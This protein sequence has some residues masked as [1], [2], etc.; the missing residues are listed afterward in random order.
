MAGAGTKT[1][2]RVERLVEVA[3]A[4]LVVHVL[5]LAVFRRYGLE[6]IGL[7]LSFRSPGPALALIL[8]LLFVRIRRNGR[9]TKG[10]DRLRPGN[11]LAG[12]G[13]PG[14][15]LTTCLVLVFWLSHHY[16]GRLGSDGVMN[17]IYVRSLVIDGDFDL[18][19]EFEDFVPEKHQFIAENARALGLTPDPTNEPGPAI[20]WAPAFVITHGLV[21]AS[22]WFGSQIPAD[23]Y[24]YPYINAVSVTSLLWGFVAV[25]VSY[26]V[27]RRYFDPRLAAISVCLLWLASTLYW[28]TVFEPTMPHATAA[29]AVSLFLYL[30]I[31][32]R[33]HPTTGGWIA[34][35][36]AGGM[37][38]A[39]QRYNVF[40]FAAPAVTAIGAVARPGLFQRVSRRSLIAA[41]IAIAGFL[42]AA[43][44]MFLYNLSHSQGLVRIG[45]LGGF[46]LRYWSSPRIGEFLFSSKH[47]LFSWTPA[48]FAAVAGLFLL[49]RKDLR[50]AATLLFTL[51]LGI[52]LLSSTWDWYAG[53]AFGSR[54][55]TEA[56]LIF[57]L[58]FCAVCEFLLRRP[59]LLATTGALAL[60]SWNMLLSGQL[61]RGEIPEMATFAFSDAAS[62]AARRTYRTLGHPGSVPANW[63]FA[64][65][66]GVSPDRFDTIYGHREFHNLTIDV[67]ASGDTHFVGRGWSEPESTS[68]GSTFRWSSGPESSFLLYLFEPYD[69]RLALMGEPSRHPKGSSQVILVNVNGQKAARLSLTE[70]WQTVEA[71]VPASFWKAGLNE[72]L[73][74][75]LWTVEAGEAYG[76][77]DGRQIA[78]KLERL[79]LQIIK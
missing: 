46:T 6:L 5:L 34:L 71:V 10:F 14:F 32:V 58:G 47:G 23:G 75:Y 13:L 2:A 67:G 73:L 8:L 61:K 41:A 42:L 4:L 63:I 60:V 20:L 54:R 11:W 22:R 65:R 51:G 19:N 44:P 16:G 12:M 49:L 29:A 68:D 30:W 62:R 3:L 18:T 1:P 9:A 79:D 28:Y 53:Y 59:K 38:L 64:W 21:R 45:D 35:A 55:M 78:V 56:F 74:T 25:A 37:V 15:I 33:E 66:Y 36:L 17:Y 24:S 50:L 7:P 26:V 39:M 72:I 77:E 52:Y 48:I 40:F 76:G 57:A 31:R 27:A 70:G 43:S 69:Y